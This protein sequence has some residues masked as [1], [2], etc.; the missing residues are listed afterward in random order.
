MSSPSYQRMRV[1]NQFSHSSVKD[2]F[3]LGVQTNYSTITRVEDSSEFINEIQ[4]ATFTM[5]AAL[6]KDAITILEYRGGVKLLLAD[7]KHAIEVKQCNYPFLQMSKGAYFDV[8]LMRDKQQRKGSKLGIGKLPTRRVVLEMVWH[9]CDVDKADIY[10]PEDTLLGLQTI[11]E[12]Y[13]FY[14]G[15]VSAEFATA[16]DMNTVKMHQLKHALKILK[17]PSKMINSK[18]IAKKRRSR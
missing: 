4:A 12:S 18:P 16:C 15:Q 13:I 3:K 11:I 1:Q 9:C 5:L 6:L 7:I 2:I 10:L 8:K 14:L 17:G